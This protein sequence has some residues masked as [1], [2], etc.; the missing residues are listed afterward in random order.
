M[1]LQEYF[2]SS[3]CI[4]TSNLNSDE[5]YFILF[6][7]PNNCLYKLL[8]NENKEVTINT[9]KRNNR[10][11]FNVSSILDLEYDFNS[12]EMI[13]N[14]VRKYYKKVYCFFLDKETNDIYFSFIENEKE[15]VLLGVLFNSPNLLKLNEN[16]TINI[17]NFLVAGVENGK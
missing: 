9:S 17:N 15:S 8:N 13:E 7:Y 3:C 6:D 14:Y 11:Y 4:C 1:S 12:K 10:I 5:I 16:E 2:N